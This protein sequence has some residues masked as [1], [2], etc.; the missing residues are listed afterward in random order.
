MRLPPEVVLSIHR[1]LD[2]A[3]D[4]S[5][6]LGA[7]EGDFD[8]VVSLNELIPNGVHWCSGLH[9]LP[10]PHFMHWNSGLSPALFRNFCLS[11]TASGK[12]PPSQ[13]PLSAKSRRTSKSSISRRRTFCIVLPRSNASKCSVCPTLSSP[14]RFH[15]LTRLLSEC[16]GTTRTASA[17]P[18]VC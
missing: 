9:S 15:L 2:D 5:D 6:L 12:R 13:R 3:Q 11:L 17:H 10:L 18:T 1:I 16:R 8:P 14:L 4:T 7:L